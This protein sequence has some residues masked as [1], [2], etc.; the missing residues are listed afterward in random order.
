MEP[1]V[2]QVAVGVV[3][4]HERKGL[5][6]HHEAV[7][8]EAGG[9]GVD[10]RNLCVVPWEA[11]KEESTSIY[12]FTECGRVKCGRMKCV[13]RLRVR[14]DITYGGIPTCRSNITHMGQYLTQ[15]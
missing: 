15:A 4:K 8:R 2:G 14:G 11:A 1:S 12:M 10:P 5:K 3:V 6:N 7:R 9:G 13:R